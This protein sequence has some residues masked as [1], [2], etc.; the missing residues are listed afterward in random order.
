M[1]VRNETKTNDT[2]K[3][4]KVIGQRDDRQDIVIDT[5]TLT[6]GTLSQSVHTSLRHS[7]V[8]ISIPLFHTHTYAHQLNYSHTFT[9]LLGSAQNSHDN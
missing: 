4:Y 7:P 5:T 9:N 6:A 1:N 3:H 2:P 8:Y